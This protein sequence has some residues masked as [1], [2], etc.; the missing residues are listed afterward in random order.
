MDKYQEAEEIVKQL[1]GIYME[2]AD[3]QLPVLR[4]NRRTVFI[5]NYSPVR[6]R[7]APR[8]SE[9]IPILIQRKNLL[10][11]NQLSPGNSVLPRKKWILSKILRM[12]RWKTP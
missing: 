8:L 7:Q 12:Q 11:L 5:G 3:V 4:T 1:L 2:I 9:Y 6:E 10:I